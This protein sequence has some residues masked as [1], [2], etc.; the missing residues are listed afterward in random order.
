MPFDFRPSTPADAPAI[1]RLCYEAGLRPR[2]DPQ[3]LPW[4]YWQP[5]ADWPGPRSFVLTNDS[6]PIAHLGILPGT[7]VSSARRAGIAQI[8]DWAAHPGEVGAGIL[9]LN[10]VSQ[11]AGPMMAV[12]GGEDTLGILPK[13]GFRAWG[14]VSGYARPL[15]PLRLLRAAPKPWWKLLPHFARSVAWTVG[16]PVAQYTDR[17]VHPIAADEVTRIALVLPVPARGMTVFGRSIE[18]FRYWASCPI[19]SMTLYAVERSGRICGYFLLAFAPGQVR[20][21]DCWVDSEEPADWRAMILLAVDEARQDPQAA[22]VV[23]WASDPLLAQALKACGF[24]ARFEIPILV[25]PLDDGS[26][27]EGPLRVQMLDNDAAYRLQE[28]KEFWA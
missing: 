12:G 11:R 2:F 9:L 21:A 17:R 15:F 16:A 24:R 27:P 22:E 1:V 19:V 28:R 23:I 14:V 7:L 13:I 3:H 10:K 5:R 4:K 18:L 8:I 25:R 20:I 6:E 26:L